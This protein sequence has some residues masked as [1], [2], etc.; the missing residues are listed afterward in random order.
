MLVPSSKTDSIKPEQNSNPQSKS[1]IDDLKHYSFNS[2]ES[3]N[4]VSQK[5]QKYIFDSNNKSCEINLYLNEDK[6]NIR[7]NLLHKDKEEYFYESDITHEQLKINNNVFKLCNNIE[8]SFEYLNYLFSDKQ[9]QLIIKEENNIIKLE[10]KI[11]LSPTL[12]I[13]F[14]KIKKEIPKYDINKDKNSENSK[15]FLFE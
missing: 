3:S 4:E 2:T 10:K 15:I 12:K 5:K 11:K 9:N 6:I 8:D 13:E 1:E 14:S 7:I